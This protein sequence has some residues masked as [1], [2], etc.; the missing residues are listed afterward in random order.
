MNEGD[1]V[2]GVK[3]IEIHGRTPQRKREHDGLSAANA[4]RTMIRDKR[5]IACKRRKVRGVRICFAAG[6]HAKW[7]RLLGEKI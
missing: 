6:F 3:A 1:L 4:Y 5:F 7:V 2:V